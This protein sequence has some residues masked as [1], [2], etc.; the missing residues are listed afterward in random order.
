MFDRIMGVTCLLGAAALAVYL[1][2]ERYAAPACDDDQV[3]AQV[4]SDIKGKVGSNGVYLLN[5]AQIAGGFFSTVR[6]CAV[7]AAPIQDS[8]TLGQSHWRKVLYTVTLDRKTGGTKVSA[9]VDGPVSP[10]FALDG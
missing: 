9:S 5:T 10:H 8:D 1:L 2:Q 3:A 6:H 7:D 4:V